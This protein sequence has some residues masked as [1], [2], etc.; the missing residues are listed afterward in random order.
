MMQWKKDGRTIHSGWTRFKVSQDGQLRIR[1]VEMDDA[2][3]Y[4]CKAT[5]GFGHVNVNYTLIVVGEYT[6]CWG[7]IRLED[8]G[9][10]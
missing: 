5:N 3:T 8:V 7:S 2:G 4:L 6:Q 9:S 1:E 10:P